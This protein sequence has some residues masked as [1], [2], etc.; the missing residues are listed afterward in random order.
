MKSFP[1]VLVLLLSFG[2]SSTTLAAEAAAPPERPALEVTTL[3]GGQFDLAAERGRWVIVNFWATWC[4]PCVKEMPD[5]SAYVDAHP[6]VR[7]IGLAFED[8][9][10]AEIDAFVA[11]HPVSY[12]LAQVDVFN[13]PADFAPPR[14]LPTTWL[15]APDGRVAHRFVGPIEAADLDREIAAA[16][17]TQPAP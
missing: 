5:I 6:E 8:T 3:D 2:L 11:R 13:P 4:A 12:P 10:R 17:A 16:K 9:E 14:G 1:T 7:A 15:I